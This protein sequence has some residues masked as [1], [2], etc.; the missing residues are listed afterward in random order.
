MIK[1]LKLE[2]HYQ[3]VRYCDI[4]TISWFYGILATIFLALWLLVVT[5]LAMIAL[6]FI[7]A[8]IATTLGIV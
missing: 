2:I 7:Y 5:C 8:I 4:W 6:S 3:W 1:W